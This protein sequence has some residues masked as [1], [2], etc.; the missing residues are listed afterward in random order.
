VSRQVL[1]SGSR[2]IRD[3][4]KLRDEI[5]AF[6]ADA[7]RLTLRINWRFTKTDARRTFGY[8]KRRIKR[9]KH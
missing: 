5:Q 9:S 1:G 3:R 2:R 4:R 8:N 6:N 7:N